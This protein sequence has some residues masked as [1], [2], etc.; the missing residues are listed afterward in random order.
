MRCNMQ[1]V[2]DLD[3]V[4]WDR[5]RKWTEYQRGNPAIP[6]NHDD[7]KADVLAFLGVTDPTMAERLDDWY[8]VQLLYDTASGDVLIGI[9]APQGT[10]LPWGDG[11]E[12]HL[13]RT[14]A[15]PQFSALQRPSGIGVGIG[16]VVV[17]GL[18]LGATLMLGGKKK[19]KRR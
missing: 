11:T 10:T 16:F 13:L 17:A 18:I 8:D 1:Y 4:T 14:C 19:R 15:K 5:A 12:V 3:A 6:I 2:T 7:L 9:W